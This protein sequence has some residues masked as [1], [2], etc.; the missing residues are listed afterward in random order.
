[1]A[2]EHRMNTPEGKRLLAALRGADYAHAGEET[3]I[4]LALADWHKSSR[5]RIL[6]AGCGRGGTA[7]YLQSHGW[8]LVTGVDRDSTSIDHA[9]KNYPHLAFAAADLTDAQ[10]LPDGPFDGIT[11]FNVLYAISD[12]AAALKALR[13]VA[14][15]GAQLMIFDYTGTAGYSK[16]ISSLHPEFGLWH[17]PVPAKMSATLQAVGWHLVTTHSLN[18]EYERWYADLVSRFTTREAALAS[19]ADEATIAYARGFYANLLHLIREGALGGAIF[20][21]EAA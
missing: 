13:T 20:H 4:E 1:M 12:Q 14:A 10:S 2:G 16:A 18:R 8:G 17:P 7:H 3:A 15:T 5:R 21:A 11:M 19:V 9:R 6:D